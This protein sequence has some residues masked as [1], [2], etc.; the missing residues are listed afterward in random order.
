MI[1]SNGYRV[2]GGAIFLDRYTAPA[3]GAPVIVATPYSANVAEGDI[4][5]VNVTGSN[6]TN[7]TY[8]WRVDSNP[9]DFKEFAGSFTMSNNIGSFSVTPTL[10]L[11]TEGNEALNISIR[12]G[13][14]T[15]P[16]LTTANAT[17][18]DTTFEL[19]QLNG[20]VLDENQSLGFNI[21]GQNIPVGPTYWYT[22]EHITTTNADFR[23]G[24]YQGTF[25]ITNSTGNYNNVLIA[26]GSDGVESDEYFNVSFRLGSA[27][28]PILAAS[29]TTGSMNTFTLRNAGS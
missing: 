21:I 1:I 5:I 12:L 19:F 14:T 29:N 16:I 23:F 20:N 27:T 8:Y 3:T 9:Q 10:D 18:L 2:T 25:P 24:T 11:V 17:I 26:E 22:V 6:I 7:G 15:G 28:G 13:T 4:L